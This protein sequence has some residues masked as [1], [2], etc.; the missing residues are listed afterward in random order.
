MN[1]EK[2]DSGNRAMSLQ[3]L[4][5]GDT[6]WIPETDSEGTVVQEI[7]PRIY[8]YTVQKQ[9]ETLRRNYWDVDN[10]ILMPNSG[11]TQSDEQSKPVSQNYPI[12]NETDSVSINPM[13]KVI[14]ELDVVIW[15]WCICNVI[16]YYLCTSHKCVYVVL[17][18]V[19]VGFI[20]CCTWV[21]NQSTLVCC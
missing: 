13:S 20:M 18:K 15:L 16:N 5:L 8:N 19:C 11:N 9:N 3:P 4:H 1:E 10:P 6:I 14:R 17:K 2:F 7:S 12:L 21:W